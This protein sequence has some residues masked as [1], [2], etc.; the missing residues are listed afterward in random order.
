MVFRIK[1]SLYDNEMN[2]FF[3]RLIKFIF[4]FILILQLTSCETLGEISGKISEYTETGYD[5]VSSVF[6]SEGENEESEEILLSKEK[7]VEVDKRKEDEISKNN[8]IEPQEEVD[9]INSSFEE[10]KISEEVLESVEVENVEVINIPEDKNVKTE[11][12]SPLKNEFSSPLEDEFSSPLENETNIKKTESTTSEKIEDKLVKKLELKNKI[13]FKIATINFNSGSSSID[14][15]GYKKIMKVL[16]LA[17]ERDAIVKIVGHASTR[18]KDMDILKHKMVNFVIS[19]KRA[20]AVAS[21][22]VKNKFPLNKLITEAVSDSKP[23]FHEVM[24]A[25]TNANQRTEIY[26]IY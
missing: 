9:N 6:S 15:N 13:Q 8:D 1:K 22:F 16:K 17:N 3:N 19:D 25:G 18:T 12:S 7:E 10:E 24:P 14:K 11:F 2:I 21:V 4:S 26:L 20:Q 5:Y 23:L